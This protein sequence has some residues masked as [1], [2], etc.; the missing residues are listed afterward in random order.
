[1][2][3]PAELIDY[4]HTLAWPIQW[5]DQDL[6]GHVNNTIYLRWFE[7]GRIGYL[8][9][10]GF[11]KLLE[12]EK[13]GP[14]LAA[15]QCNFKRQL[16]YPDQVLIG[17]RV[18]RIGRTSFTMEHVIYSTALGSIAATGDSTI[19]AFDYQRQI[20]TPVPAEMRRAMEELAGKAL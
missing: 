14:I 16:R 2:H 8:E 20:P 7:S 5:G 18:A 15:V 13:I 3:I 11:D 1:M 4:A 6:Y 12:R 10:I 19:V 9:K 17:S